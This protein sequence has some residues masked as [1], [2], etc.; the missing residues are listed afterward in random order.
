MYKTNGEK[1]ISNSR[2]QTYVNKDLKDNSEEIL[3]AMGLSINEAITIFLNRVVATNSLPIELKLTDTEKNKLSI[4]NS[5]K[6]IPTKK[7]NTETELK[8]W[9]DED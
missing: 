1:K 7:I 9:L 2:I 3:G 5:A 8:K 4:A 6:K